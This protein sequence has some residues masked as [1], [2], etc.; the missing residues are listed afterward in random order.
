[1]NTKPSVL[2]LEFFYWVDE[3]DNTRYYLGGRFWFIERADG[4]CVF[5]AWAK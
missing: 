5:A 1:M 3:F 2:D 4:M